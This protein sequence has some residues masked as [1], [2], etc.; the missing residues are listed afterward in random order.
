MRETPSR[1]GLV[2]SDMVR[3]ELGEYK[4][5]T[6]RERPLWKKK[7]GHHSRHHSRITRASQELVALDDNEANSYTF[8]ASH[9]AHGKSVEAV[10]ERVMAHPSDIRI[11]LPSS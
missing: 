10:S 7:E 2:T 11:H 6:P 5:Y 4:P 3:G 1:C 8:Q 9:S